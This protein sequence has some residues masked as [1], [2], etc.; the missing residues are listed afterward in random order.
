MFKYN[1]FN[2]IITESI[3][4]KIIKHYLK[5]KSKTTVLT[6]KY[7]KYISQQIQTLNNISYENQEEIS[8]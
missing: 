6:N 1:K 2:S 8:Q 5:K 4:L 7:F 3:W